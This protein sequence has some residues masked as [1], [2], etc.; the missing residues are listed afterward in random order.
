MILASLLGT[1]VPGRGFQDSRLARRRERRKRWTRKR[2]HARPENRPSGLA[3]S[4]LLETALNLKPLL[5]FDDGSS[6][7]SS[8]GPRGVRSGIFG[9]PYGEKRFITESVWSTPLVGCPT[10]ERAAERGSAW[11]S[12]RGFSPYGTQNRSGKASLSG[13]ASL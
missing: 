13:I 2:S 8:L 9:R 1:G 11:G 4:V 10:A 5:G 3:K 6:G 12:E 7:A